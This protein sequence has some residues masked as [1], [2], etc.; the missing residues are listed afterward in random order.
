MHLEIPALQA[1]LRRWRCALLVHPDL[2]R[3]ERAV[4][5]LAAES[6]WPRLS[7][8]G[9]LSALLLSVPPERRPGMVEPLMESLLKPFSPGPVLCTEIDLL[10]VPELRLAP[11]KLLRQLSR[12]AA[13]LVAWPGSHSQNGLVYAV[14]EHTGYTVFRNP[15][16]A[17]YPL[18]EDSGGKHAL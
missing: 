17:V 3:L 10:F 14:P 16:V 13:L 9:R 8:G 2:G 15:E 11:L 4:Q 1:D 12:T 18:D 5:R 7:I 6:G